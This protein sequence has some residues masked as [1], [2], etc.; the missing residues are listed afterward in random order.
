MIS[1]NFSQTERLTR[2]IALAACSMGALVCVIVTLKIVWLL[3]PSR[4]NDLV[5]HSLPTVPSATTPAVVSIAKWHLFGNPDAGLTSASS[6]RTAPSTLKLFLRGTLALD[7]PRTGMAVIGDDQGE[8]AYHV[9]EMVADGARLD[10]VFTDH[11]IIF[12]EGVSQTL[13]LPRLDEPITAPTVASS[14]PTSRVP[15]G[16]AAPSDSTPRS[17]NTAIGKSSEQKLAINP[18][19]LARQIQAVPVMENGQFTGVRLNAGVHAALLSKYGWQPNDI[20]TAINGTSVTN[21]ANAQQL[22]DNLKMGGQIQVTVKRDGK[23]ATLTV[24]LR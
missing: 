2:L 19:E 13:T 15:G 22:M 11:V 24:S 10:S 4:N 21:L 1:L 3:I 5:P 6:A 8:H 23:P 17:G 12:H 16:I 20:V 7:N 18:A 9:G 14:T